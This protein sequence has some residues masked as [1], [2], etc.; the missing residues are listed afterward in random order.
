MRDTILIRIR[1][2]VKLAQLQLFVNR[3]KDSVLIH[4]AGEESLK[5]ELA[6]GKGGCTVQSVSRQCECQVV[7]LREKL[8]AKNAVVGC[9]VQYFSDT[10]RSSIKFL[11]QNFHAGVDRS[12]SG[13]FRVE[14][15]DVKLHGHAAVDE[16]TPGPLGSVVS[17]DG[18]AFTKGNVVVDST[19]DT[20]VIE[21]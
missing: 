2:M 3:P 15:V 20:D 9:I 1:K 21:L 19:S 14:S 18:G 16:I 13:A 12:V 6:K 17:R 11:V 4:E 10:V 8:S 5:A 7:D